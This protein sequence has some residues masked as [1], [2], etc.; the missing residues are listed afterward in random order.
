MVNLGSLSGRV[1]AGQRRLRETPRR[2]RL[3]HGRDRPREGAKWLDGK[4]EMIKGPGRRRRRGFRRQ[5]GRFAHCRHELQP[6]ELPPARNRL[7]LVSS[8]RRDVLPVE[9][10]ALGSEL[11]YGFIRGHE[12]RRPC[13]RGA[14]SFGLDAESVVWFDGEPFMLRDYLRDHGVPD[15]FKG[16]VNTGFI[17]D[18]SPDGRI[19][20]GYGAGRRRS[21]AT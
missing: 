5:L 7:D 16:W 11:P 15:A 21:R 9:R 12:R 10:P 2:H 6:P 14:L 17:T 8:H 4:Q 3:G 18:V 20:V 19:L 13:D 1:H